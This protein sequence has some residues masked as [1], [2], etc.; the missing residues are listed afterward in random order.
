MQ[1]HDKIKPRLRQ[2]GVAEQNLKAKE[3][4]SVCAD[5]FEKKADKDTEHSETCKI[6]WKVSY[7]HLL[8]NLLNGT[9]GTI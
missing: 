9:F 8:K 2:T 4:F 5:V 3:K 7:H 6:V 1:C